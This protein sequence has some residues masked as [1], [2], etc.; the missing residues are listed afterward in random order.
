MLCPKENNNSLGREFLQPRE[1]TIATTRGNRNFVV[2]IKKTV[3]DTLLPWY[4][5]EAYLAPFI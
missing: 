2:R 5:N 1:E 4:G 3:Q